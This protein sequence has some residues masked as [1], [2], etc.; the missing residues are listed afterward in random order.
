MPVHLVTPS[1]TKEYSATPAHEP[2]GLDGFVPTS[3]EPERGHCNRRG[4]R[5]CQVLQLAE[6]TLW[7]CTPSAISR[8][9]DS[10]GAA[11]IA[12][13]L[14]VPDRAQSA[15]SGE[16]MTARPPPLYPALY[17]PHGQVQRGQSV[18]DEP[19]EGGQRAGSSGLL[20]LVIRIPK[21]RRR[22]GVQPCRVG[23]S[24]GRHPYE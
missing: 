1:P 19:P 15:V 3:K 8:P 14:C 6:Q 22:Y 4:T 12:C 7:P 11:A 2:H 21:A 17:P 10:M 24:F 20:Q 18:P 16:A 9:A 23:R 13:T 5:P